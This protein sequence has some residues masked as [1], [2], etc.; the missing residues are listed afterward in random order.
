M[1]A[2]QIEVKVAEYNN[3][4]CAMTS[5]L[6]GGRKEGRNQKGKK[7]Y[8]QEWKEKLNKNKHWERAERRSEGIVKQ[9][10]CERN[11]WC[12]TNNWRQA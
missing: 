8:K 6:M 4:N 11:E 2:S 9:T 5:Y 12:D 3:R 7:E 1:F 10:E